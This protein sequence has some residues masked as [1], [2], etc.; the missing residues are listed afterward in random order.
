[1]DPA[2]LGSTACASAS[3]MALPTASKGHR[4][5]SARVASPSA[6]SDTA[7][8]PCR[9]VHSKHIALVHSGHRGKLARC[10]STQ[11]A[12]GSPQQLKR[13]PA[14]PGG[15]RSYID[16]FESILR[17]VRRCDGRARRS[18]WSH[19]LRLV[20]ITLLSSGRP[21]RL[22]WAIARLQLSVASKSVP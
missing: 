14:A 2:R 20:Q 10:S 7:C 13:P 19:Q 18:C 8:Y 15:C 17:V 12:P 3:L 6:A 16:C 11:A 4:T 21:V 9:A 5:E 22:L 1:M